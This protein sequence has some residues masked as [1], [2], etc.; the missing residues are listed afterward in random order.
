MELTDILKRKKI[1]FIEVAKWGICLRKQWEDNFA[2]H[3]NLEE[4]KAIYLYNDDGACGYLWHLFSYKKRNCFEG[5]EAEQAFNDEQKISCYV[6]YQHIDDVLILDRAEMFNANDLVNES[7]IY[8]LDKEF[9]WTYV[10]IHET[11]WCGPYFSRRV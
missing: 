9:K 11:G 7:D 3:L 6:F 4:K 5:E 8:I 2:N 1:K 10:K